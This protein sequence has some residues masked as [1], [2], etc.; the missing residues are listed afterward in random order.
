MNGILLKF[1][2]KENDIVQKPNVVAYDKVVLV[3]T[4]VHLHFL[5]I[6]YCNV[7][8]ILE[9]CSFS[10]DS[11]ESFFACRDFDCLHPDNI[12]ENNRLAF[13][14]AE[15]QLGIPALL[16]AEDMVDNPV[17]DRLSVL[18]YVSQYYQAFSSMGLTLGGCSPKNSPK[19]DCR[20]DLAANEVEKQKENIPN[21]SYSPS[22]INKK[23]ENKRV[24]AIAPP[25]KIKDPSNIKSPPPNSALTPKD[26]KKFNSSFPNQSSNASSAIK[27]RVSASPPTSNIAPTTST[28]YTSPYTSTYTSPYSSKYRSTA[29]SNSSLNSISS[30]SS[31]SSLTASTASTPSSNFSSAILSRGMP[32][33]N[34]TTTTTTS[35][36]TQPLK[37]ATQPLKSADKPLAPKAKVA[38]IQERIRS[39]SLATS[40]NATKVTYILFA[41]ICL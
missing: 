12:L 32:E 22:V 39:L 10:T 41:I 29:A 6:F 37:T 3:F 36:A 31:S 27:N 4:E 9:C 11:N 24:D 8:C 2:K 18:T 38:T 30:Q 23:A 7:L 26:S 35:P 40:S 20:I 14:V 28:T 13:S 5:L 17:P 21:Q 34:A 25:T 19:A 15:E 33:T 16:D 1:L